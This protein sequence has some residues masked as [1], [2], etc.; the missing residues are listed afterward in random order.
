MQYEKVGRLYGPRACGARL[1]APGAPSP[2][3]ALSKEAR[4]VR[5]GVVLA[6]ELNLPAR[7]LSPLNAHP[8]LDDDIELLGLLVT[9][10]EEVLPHVGVLCR[11]REFEC[12]PVRSRPRDRGI[13][14]GTLA[15]G[16]ACV[17]RPGEALQGLHVTLSA[18]LATEAPSQASLHTRRS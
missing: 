17:P 15:I 2:E 9:L 6:D 3:G 4:V 12:K 16:D 13:F 8:P 7:S 1:R 5:A 18:A 10:C 11:A 14:K